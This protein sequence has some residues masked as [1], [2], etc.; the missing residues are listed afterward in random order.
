MDRL[1][2]S[3]R[4][5]LVDDEAAN[6]K[7]LV[8]TLEGQGYTNLVPIQDSRKVLEEYQRART[9][10]ILLDLRMPYLDGFEVMARLRGIDDPLRPPIVVL[11]AEK[12]RDYLMQAFASGARDYLTKPFE[13][14][15]L[16]A[17][18]RNMLAVHMSQLLLY[19]Q[20]ETLD[21]IVRARTEELLKTRMQVIEKLGRASEYRDN[22]TGRHILRVG[23]TAALLAEKAGMGTQYSEDITHAAPMHDVGK[24]GIPDAILLKPGKLDPEEYEVMKGHAVIGARLLEGEEAGGILSLAKEIALSHHEK[25]NGSGY[26]AG[27][28]GQDIPKSGRIVALADVFDA[29][30]SARPYKE[31]WTVEKA[32][33]LIRENRGR[34]FDPGLTDLFLG[35]L[36][37]IV[38]IKDRLPDAK[39]HAP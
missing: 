6:L 16:L 35:L 38:A 7:L 11:T 2:K 13:I 36:P 9:N 39:E 18:V 14:E 19:E 30:T 33:D 25:W 5:L 22:E 29:L 34:H 10:L 24:I 27:L 28:A 32:R 12:G 8:K 15:E 20:R 37:E 4:I 3:E 1:L 23:Q 26:P 31:A 21:M 17:R